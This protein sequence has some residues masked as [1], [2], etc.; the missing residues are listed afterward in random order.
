MKN[1]QEVAKTIKEIAKAQKKPVGTMLE[2]C[3]LSK[4]ALSSMKAGYYPQLENLVAIADY[5]DCS[6]DYLL[7]RNIKKGAPDNIRDAIIQRI[8]LLPDNKLDRLLG[9]LEG[10]QAE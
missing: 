3:G 2:T 1:S 9:F 7:G 5:L 10:L 6:V 8:N 4:N